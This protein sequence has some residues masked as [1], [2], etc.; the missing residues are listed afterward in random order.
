MAGLRQCIFDGL[1]LRRHVFVGGADIK[2]MESLD[3]AQVVFVD[4]A[5]LGQFVGAAIGGFAQQQFVDTVKCIG[6]HNSQ[7]VVQIETE[8]FE[9]IVID[10]LGAL[11]THD[12]FAGEHLHVDDRAL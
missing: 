5:T 1:E 12:A 6:F 2:P 9:F 4:L 8:T 3:A 10:L 11:V 7:L